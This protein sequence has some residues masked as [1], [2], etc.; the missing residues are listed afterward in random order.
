MVEHLNTKLKIPNI[1]HENHVL[2]FKTKEERQF[3][4]DVKSLVKSKLDDVMNSN[5]SQSKMMIV[6]FELI[7]RLRQATIHPQLVIDGLNKKKKGTHELH[8]NGQSSKISKLVDLL[9]ERTKTENC[10]VFSHFTKEID[11]LGKALNQRGLV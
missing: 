11:I 8:F 6:I 1:K 10:I 7:L 4:E 5:M 3:Y 2:H 9:E